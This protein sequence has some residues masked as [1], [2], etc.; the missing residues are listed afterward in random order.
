MTTRAP[1]HVAGGAS[2][3]AAQRFEAAGLTQAPLTG[4][5]APPGDGP[6]FRAL[7]E[8]LE[9]VAAELRELVE[10][11]DAVVGETHFP[12]PEETTVVPQLPP[13]MRP[14]SEIEW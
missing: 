13:P 11:E 2:S 10:E 6:I 8:G 1:V 7:A 4:W 14:A 9:G 5:S 12:R 3:A